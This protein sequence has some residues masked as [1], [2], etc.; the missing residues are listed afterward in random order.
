M[1]SLL[2]MYV[3]PIADMLVDLLQ[4]MNYFP[5]WTVSRGITK[6]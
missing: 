6:S 5:S 4:I 1:L 2:K 3:M